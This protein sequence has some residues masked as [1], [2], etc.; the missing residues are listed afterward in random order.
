MVKER[1]RETRDKKH[2]CQALEGLPMNELKRG[3]S[4]FSGVTRE[5]AKDTGMIIALI[6]LLLAYYLNSPA[7]LPLAAA[8]L[9]LNLLACTIFKPIAKIWIAFSHLLGRATSAIIL[10]ILFVCMVVPVGVFRRL[11]GLDSLSL[12]QWKKDDSSVFK[13]RDHS[14]EPADLDKPY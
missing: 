7:S 11:A 8:V 4:F 6:C 14:F 2:G 10:S 3:V 1:I 12:N 5:E 9:F 13:R